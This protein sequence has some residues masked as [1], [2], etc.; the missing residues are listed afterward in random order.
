MQIIGNG[1]NFGSSFTVID[2][3]VDGLK[4]LV[5]G[6]GN[7]CLKAHPVNVGDINGDLIDDLVIGAADC[8]SSLSY[9]VFGMQGATWS[10]GAMTIQE[11]ISETNAMV[12]GETLTRSEA[13][14]LGGKA[15][16]AEARAKEVGKAEDLEGVLEKK[17]SGEPLTASERGILGGHARKGGSATTGKKDEGED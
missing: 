2:L 1:N 16:K 6:T 14:K 12:H 4:D 11:F 9:V 5:I 3:N 13:G 17:Q 8:D 7:F 10:K 15:Y